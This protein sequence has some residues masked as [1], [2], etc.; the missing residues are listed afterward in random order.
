MKFLL[1]EIF[2]LEVTTVM[3]VA[4]GIVRYEID[5]LR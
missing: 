1:E 5:F 3:R 4:L 2:L